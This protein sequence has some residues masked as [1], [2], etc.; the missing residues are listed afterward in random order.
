LIL[1]S[2]VTYEIFDPEDWRM[3]EESSFIH[4]GLCSESQPMESPS[5]VLYNMLPEKSIS[6]NKSIACYYFF[7]V[8]CFAGGSGPRGLVESTQLGNEIRFGGPGV[9]IVHL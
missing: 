1:L 6:P 7:I 4:S 5:R 9:P 2:F 8:F 3:D